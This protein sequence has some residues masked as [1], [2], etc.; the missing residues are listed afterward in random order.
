MLESYFIL[1][2]LVLASLALNTEKKG[3]NELQLN[4]LFEVGVILSSFQGVIHSRDKSPGLSC[5][6]FI[7]MS[8][9]CLKSHSSQHCT[10]AT[11]KISLFGFFPSPKVSSLSCLGLILTFLFFPGSYRWKTLLVL[12][13]EHVKSFEM[14]NLV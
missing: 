8:A 13:P 1:T 2:S 3:E 14:L 6:F 9:R 5:P 12:D 10:Y 4:L 11:Y 7:Y